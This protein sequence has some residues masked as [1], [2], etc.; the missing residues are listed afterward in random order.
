MSGPR[1]GG[2]ARP[3]I[4]S[5]PLSKG[6]ANSRVDQGLMIRIAAGAE[7]RADVDIDLDVEAL[8]DL[9]AV[10]SLGPDED[11]D[12]LFDLAPEEAGTWDDDDVDWEGRLD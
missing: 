7:A 11:A 4:G 3:D 5:K 12:E 8:A 10:W 2:A 9:R 6:K 1:V